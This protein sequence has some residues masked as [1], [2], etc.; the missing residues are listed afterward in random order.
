[1]FVMGE[2]VA[3]YNGAYKVQPLL[4]DFDDLDEGGGFA[5]AAVVNVDDDGGWLMVGDW[6]LVAVVVVGGLQW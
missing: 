3:Q 5:A 4:G 2:E 1:M 6:L